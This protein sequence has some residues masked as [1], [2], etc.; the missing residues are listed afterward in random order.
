[1]GT[2]QFDTKTIIGWI[3]IVLISVFTS[4][5]TSSF[6]KD[7]KAQDDSKII[8]SQQ[9]EINELQKTDQKLFNSLEKINKSVEETHDNI[10]ILMD[11]HGLIPVKR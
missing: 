9:I 7:Q 5:A 8:A 4:S 3:I 2:S 10:I 11:R 6:S 1:M